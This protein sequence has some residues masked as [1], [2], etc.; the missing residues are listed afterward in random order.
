[1]SINFDVGFGGWL[2][3]R[4]GRGVWV[5]D[6]DYLVIIRPNVS[7]RLRQFLKRNSQQPTCRKSSFRKRSG[8]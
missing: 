1:M 2:E 7:G 3:C 4:R 6:G 5:C 8:S